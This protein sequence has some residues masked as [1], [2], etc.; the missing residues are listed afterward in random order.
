MKIKKYKKNEKKYLTRGEQ[1]IFA[2][3]NRERKLSLT[4]FP[5]SYFN[6]YF[7]LFNGN[8]N[9]SFKFLFLP[10]SFMQVRAGWYGTLYTVYIQYTGAIETGL[11]GNGPKWNLSK[12]DIV[13]RRLNIPPIPPRCLNLTGNLS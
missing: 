8:F 3:G 13:S 2:E 12:R 1:R 6:L 9:S 10:F 11:N 5:P 7:K 4:P